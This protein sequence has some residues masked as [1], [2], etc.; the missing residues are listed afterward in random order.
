MM[1][2]AKYSE[3]KNNLGKVHSFQ[4][5]KKNHWFEWKKIF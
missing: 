5:K 1:K 3:L 2:C 4:K